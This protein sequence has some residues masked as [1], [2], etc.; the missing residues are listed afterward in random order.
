MVRENY[1]KVFIVTEDRNYAEY[2][3]NKYQG[4]SIFYE[5]FRSKKNEAFKTYP[6]NMHRYKLGKEIIIQTMFLVAREF[7]LP[8]LTFHLQHQ[9]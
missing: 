8:F 2:L 5:S 4:N 7:Y 6:R 9:C 3:K 1:K